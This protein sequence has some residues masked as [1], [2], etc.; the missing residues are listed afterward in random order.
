MEL[1]PDLEAR[2][3]ETYARAALGGERIRFQQ[4]SEAMGRWFDVFTM[5]IEPRGRP[6]MKS[7]GGAADVLW[8]DVFAVGF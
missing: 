3:V 5:P 6:S 2:W 8:V 4:G 7:G 1:V